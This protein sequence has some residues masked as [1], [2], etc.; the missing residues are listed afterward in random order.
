MPLNR[1]YAFVSPRWS[2]SITTCGRGYSCNSFPIEYAKAFVDA[3]ARLW[4]TTAAYYNALVGV[5]NIQLRCQE[6][7][8][9]ARLRS[10]GDFLD[11]FASAVDSRVNAAV[12]SAKTLADTAA[13]AMGAQNSLAS[14][15]KTS[16]GT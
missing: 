5:A 11:Y 10:D 13:S 2:P 14:L 16:E 1:A 7:E 6:L 3:K 15:S 12:S 8:L 9:D 4:T